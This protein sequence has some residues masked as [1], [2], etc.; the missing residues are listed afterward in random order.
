[1]TAWLHDCMVALV[2]SKKSIGINIKDR[3]IKLFFVNILVIQN[4][5]RNIALLKECP[6]S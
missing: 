3:K 2:P 5:L 4:K 6:F 1:M